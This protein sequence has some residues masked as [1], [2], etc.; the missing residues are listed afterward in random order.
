MREK[1]FDFM[2]AY[3][4][5]LS[6]RNAYKRDQTIRS[7]VLVGIILVLSVISVMTV[8]YWAVYATQW[9]IISLFAQVLL[10]FKS[11]LPFAKR[12]EALK[13]ITQ[14]MQL[15]LYDIEDYWNRIEYSSD[16]KPSDIDIQAQITTF[17]KKDRDIQERFAAD[18]D[19]PKKENLIK[20]A[21][22]ETKLHCWYEYNINEQEVTHYVKQ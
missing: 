6:Y 3:Y 21:E 16:S 2:V 19:F 7:T 10:A 13:Y 20:V 5:N 17:K 14:D 9:S 8:S 15:L 11:L 18:I 22:E 1:Y 12:A 4:H